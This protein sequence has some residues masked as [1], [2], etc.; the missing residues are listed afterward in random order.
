MK[1]IKNPVVRH[2][3]VGCLKIG[4]KLIDILLMF[5][6]TSTKARI[7]KLSKFT[8]RLPKN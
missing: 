3:P 1:V 8:E 5:I 4:E 2:L 6:G 7:V